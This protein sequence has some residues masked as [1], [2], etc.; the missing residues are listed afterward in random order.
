MSGLEFALLGCVE[1]ALHKTLLPELN[2]LL[3]I[4]SQRPKRKWLLLLRARIFFYLDDSEALLLPITERK[5]KEII[6]N[7]LKNVEQIT[8]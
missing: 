8:N 3:S 5:P 1:E 2:F 7:S 4:Y 6:P